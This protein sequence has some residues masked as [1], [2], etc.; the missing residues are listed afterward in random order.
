MIVDQGKVLCDSGNRAVS[1]AMEQD[2]RE[3][4][5]VNRRIGGRREMLQTVRISRAGVLAM[6]RKV[7][8]KT[9]LLST[10]ASLV[11][12]YRGVIEEILQEWPV[13]PNSFAWLQKM[14]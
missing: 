4:L 5:D 13:S 9:M 6:R 10:Y 7:R 11:V 14:R 1:A 2:E 8:G 12:Y 3:T